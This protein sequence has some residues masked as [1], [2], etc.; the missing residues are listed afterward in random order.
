MCSTRCLAMV[1]QRL[2]SDSG[3]PWRASTA[4]LHERRAGELKRLGLSEQRPLPWVGRP[5]LQSLYE[6]ALAAQ[7]RADPDSTRHVTDK[8][9]PV[10]W[11][12][13]MSVLAAVQQVFASAGLAAIEEHEQEHE[14]A[15]AGA[16]RP[17]HGCS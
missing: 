10:G 1:V 13:D 11:K 12:R 17:A 9:V 2:L 8:S 15:A 16:E 3:R 14:L 6:R 7:V 5:S 4:K